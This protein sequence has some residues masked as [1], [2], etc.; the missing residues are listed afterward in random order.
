M[1]PSSRQFFSATLAPGAGGFLALAASRSQTDGAPA[2]FAHVPRAAAPELQSVVGPTETLSTGGALVF[3]RG[4]DLRGGADLGVLASLEPV[5]SAADAARGSLVWGVSSALAVFETPPMRAA[6]AATLRLALGRGCSSCPRGSSSS[7]A[8]A[9]RP[10][11]E[12][13]GPVAEPKSWF[14]SP[15]AGGAG[16]TVR[17]TV[18]SPTP[19]LGGAGAGCRFGTVAVS[20]S[21]TTA[22]SVE[23]VAPALKPGVG[24]VETTFNGR[25]YT[26]DGET[27][28]KVAHPPSAL[29]GAVPSAVP[30]T[31]PDGVV[32]GVDVDSGVFDAAKREQTLV[33][34]EGF[35]VHQRHFEEETL[36]RCGV[37]R[38][39]FAIQRRFAKLH[40]VSVVGEGQCS[41]AVNHAGKLIEG[42][43]IRQHVFERAI[44]NRVVR[45]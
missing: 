43:N 45:R 40:G 37:A 9:T 27:R 12:T 4:R 39:S 15:A 10:L 14:A 8:L 44:L 6:G 29:I 30:A 13:R 3:L 17:V 42:D 1:S 25:E 19:F 21:A 20:A 2:V 11:G 16:T 22:T 32:F 31:A 18:A 35:G 36:E 41:F 33:I 23:C 26:D 38:E 24:V 34:G 5:A 28:F 7:L